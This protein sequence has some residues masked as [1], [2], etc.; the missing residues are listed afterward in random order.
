M[1]FHK[2]ADI[3]DSINLEENIILYLYSINQLLK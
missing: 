1:I 2:K 3:I